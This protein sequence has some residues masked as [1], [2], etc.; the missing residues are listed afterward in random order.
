MAILDAKKVTVGETQKLSGSP[1]S[2]P[3]SGGKIHPCIIPSR[4]NRT[5][6]PLP[7]NCLRFAPTYVR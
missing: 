2:F 5:S 3:V 6:L 4:K 7:E 1:I